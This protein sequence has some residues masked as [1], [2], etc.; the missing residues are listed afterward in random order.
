MTLNY[1]MTQPYTNNSE[2][3]VSRVSGGSRGQGGVGGGSLYSALCPE[4]AETTLQGY[5]CAVKISY[6][7]VGYFCAVKISDFI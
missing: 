4:Y 7:A 5:F 6:L 3:P 2:M 1:N